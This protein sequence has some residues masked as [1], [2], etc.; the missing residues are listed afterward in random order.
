[1]KRS[2]QLIFVGHPTS[3]TA[4]A[5]W[6][7]PPGELWIKIAQHGGLCRKTSVKERWER[8]K[9]F[10]ML[11]GVELRHENIVEVFRFMHLLEHE[12][13]CH[14]CY[15]I[16]W[17]SFR[18]YIRRYFAIVHFLID[19]I[20]VTYLKLCFFSDVLHTIPTIL[21]TMVKESM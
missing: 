18:A 12:A 13:F 4:S 10:D 16:L 14:C 9:I 7:M 1:M 3:I 20:T 6:L 2:F 5:I 17:D 15:I 19:L 21:I 8:L 11:Y